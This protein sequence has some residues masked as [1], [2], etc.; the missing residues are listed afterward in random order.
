MVEETAFFSGGRKLPALVHLPAVHLGVDRSPTVVMAHGLAND[1]DEAGQFPPLAERLAA[2][3]NV[4]VRFDFRGGVRDVAPGR[5]LPAT[6]WPLDL[7]AAI[8]FARGR[9]DVDPERVV[10][11]GASCGGS[12]AVQIAALEHQLRGVVTLGSFADGERWLRELWTR[13][14][15][16]GRWASFLEEVAEDRR[17]R[18]S[19]HRSRRL[20]LVGEFL[21]VPDEDL[22]A[23]EQF[24]Q[25]NPGMVRQLALEVVD[26]LFLLSPERSAAR[27][28]SPVL[29]VHGSADTLVPVGEAER[30]GRA[31]GSRAECVT[32]E[33]GPHQL[34]LGEGRDHLVESLSRWVRERFTI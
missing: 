31:L 9:V 5:Q 24:V 15:S 34:L 17:R 19:G 21:P 7:L 8:A 6:E 16:A 29:V 23:A 14:H 28:R 4:V 22:A 12:V 1:R 3:G 27:V 11:I 18:V 13:V 2:D 26:D 25:A 10:V 33:G 32:V 30:F 20:D